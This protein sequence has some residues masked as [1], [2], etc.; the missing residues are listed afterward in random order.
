MEDR[1]IPYANKVGAEYY[2][3]APPGTPE[4]GYMEHNRQ[5]IQTAIGEGREVIDVGPHPDRVN[6]PAPT[7]PY[8]AMELKE[9][10]GY[11]NYLRIILE[12]P[13]FFLKSSAH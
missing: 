2:R 9:L 3:G 11:P 6:Y 4:I 7:S 5:A 13:E 12:E 8:Y 10:S 1:V